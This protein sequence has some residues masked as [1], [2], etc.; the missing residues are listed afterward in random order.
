M[1]GCSTRRCWPGSVGG[2]STV[3]DPDGDDARDGDAL[4]RAE[5]RAARRMEFTLT[6]DGEGGSWLRGRLDPAGAATVRAALDPLARP[7]PSAADGPDPRSPG[8]RRADA[9]VELCRRALTAGDLPDNGGERPQVVVT[10]PY[11]VLRD[12]IGAAT[13]DDGTVISAAE[14]RRLAC[15]ATIIPAVLGGPSQVLDLGRSRRLFTG[16]ARRALALT[17][18]RL[19]VPRLRPP[20]RLVRR[21]P[22][23]RLGQR[24]HHHVDN[25]VLLCGHHHRL[26][27]RRH[28]E[29][30][31]AADGIP[32]FRPPPWTDPN[33]R[34]LRNHLHKRE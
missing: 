14:A 16:A 28:W 32:E 19:R 31:I 1:P 21:P 11:A 2:C 5:Q 25:G 26:I 34:P 24:R 8:R 12:G 17:R 30:I 15:D 22:H 13:L 29:I 9:L 3:A 10:V 7:R 6:P 27:E 33:Q 23:H 18:P 4:A 20:D